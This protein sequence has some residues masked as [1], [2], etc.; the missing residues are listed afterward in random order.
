M[1]RSI[2]ILI[3]TGVIAATAVGIL[4]VS[5]DPYQ[6][7]F[8]VRALFFGGLGVVGL[9]LAGLIYYS[10]KLLFKRFNKS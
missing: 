1:H 3:G 4:A 6:A 5:Y 9:S 2:F 7:S 10:L 8:S